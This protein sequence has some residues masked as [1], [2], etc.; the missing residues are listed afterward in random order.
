LRRENIRGI[1][2]EHRVEYILGVLLCAYIGA[3]IG[4]KKERTLEGALLGLFLGPL[5]W[6]AAILLYPPGPACPHCG[7]AVQ[8]GY[9]V[10]KHCGRDFPPFPIQKSRLFEM[11]DLESWWAASKRWVIA[12]AV[13]LFII[14]LAGLAWGLYYSQAI[15]ETAIKR[16][17]ARREAIEAREKAE[18][19]R[20]ATEQQ[21]EEAARRAAA[22]REAQQQAETQRRQ[23]Q[24]EISKAEAQRTREE[25]ARI[26]HQ[27]Y[28][29]RTAAEEAAWAARN[30]DAFPALAAALSG[31]S[32]LTRQPS[33][34][35]LSGFKRKFNFG[36]R[37]LSEAWKSYNNA[38]GVPPGPISSPFLR[39][40]REIGEVLYFCDAHRGRVPNG[41]LSRSLL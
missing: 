10:C 33:G 23:A 14:V 9:A 8:G 11:V 12:G 36:C 6:L 21:K 13:A 28:M 3:L 5:G 26:A 25:A 38:V 32:E 29:E 20:V 2:L 7:G 22:E 35:M 30:R 31:L 24:I 15:E 16:E 39:L 27:Q 4:S 41:S 18:L 19:A 40:G 37:T 34:M 17:R 1:M